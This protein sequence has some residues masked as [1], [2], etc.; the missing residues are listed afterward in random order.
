MDKAS[1]Y[2]HQHGFGNVQELIKESLRE[3]VFGEVVISNEELLLV[4]KLAKVTEE[5]NLWG[6]EEELF[7]KLRR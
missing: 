4:K 6:T 3:R 2:A 1:A 7:E 5:K